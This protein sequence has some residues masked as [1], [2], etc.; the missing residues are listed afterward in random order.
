M[1]RYQCPECEAVLKRETPVPAGKKIKCPKCEVVFAPEAIREAGAAPDAV[2]KKAKA[3]KKSAPADDEEEEGGAY[4]LN[5]GGEE[6]S[7]EK[8]K[9][10]VNYGSLRDK[11]K[12]SK[13]GPAMARV[14]KLTNAQM[15]FGIIH[16][17]LYLVGVMGC[18]WPF[19]FSD[20][21]PSGGAGQWIAG[22]SGCAALL[23]YT[24]CLCI[25][26]SKMHTLE[27]YSWAMAGAVLTLVLGMIWIVVCII[28]T[29][30]AI[31][32]MEEASEVML[33][34]MMLAVPYSLTIGTL[35]IGGKAIARLRE[36]AVLEGFEET[37]NTVTDY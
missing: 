13:R 37:K 7:E 27:S 10:K 34:C 23:I 31:K 24:F 14:V 15:L 29:L 4:E 18:L 20:K 5:K 19:I 11:F 30:K 17:V 2:K 26:S 21:P 35:V 3:V 12:K 8:K 9:K 25:G 22:A 33:Y 1:P 6:T 16:A 28:A 32:E 36:P